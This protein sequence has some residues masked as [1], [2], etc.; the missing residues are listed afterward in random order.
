MQMYWKCEECD[1]TNPYPQKRICVSCG[2][3]MSE[4]AK[5]K[6]IQN[7]KDEEA[8]AEQKYKM[9]QLR[10]KREGEISKQD[11]KNDGARAGSS[12]K[13]TKSIE[14][15]ERIR[16]KKE[17]NEIKFSKIYIMTAQ[18]ASIV[19]RSLIFVAVILAVVVCAFNW[20]NTDFIKVQDEFKEKVVN[21]YIALTYQTEEGEDLLAPRF[22]DNLS[23]ELETMLDHYNPID[24]VF[25]L[26]EE[27]A[28]FISGGN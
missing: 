19:M 4:Q 12:S 11:A 7:K 17:K 26:A 5:Q 15:R 16:K 18:V 14:E 25:G 3:P 2:S 22:I 20:D 10:K 6:A 24:N 8:L 28:K 23:R 13:Y 27:T 21:S 1:E 9:E